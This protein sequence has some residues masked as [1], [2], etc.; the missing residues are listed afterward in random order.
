MSPKTRIAL[1][2]ATLLIASLA[3]TTI[4]QGF[5]ADTPTPPDTPTDT[6]TPLPI[7]STAPAASSSAPLTGSEIL[8]S[9]DFSD[10]SSGWD[11]YSDAE[12]YT[13]YA[14]GAYQ[15]GIYTDNYFY[16]ANPYL[17][18]GDVIVTVEGEKIAGDDDMEYGII[19]HHVDVNNWYAL[20]IS[21]DGYAYIG[22]R[23]QGGDMENITG[24][25][26]APAVNTGNAS[27]V[28]QAECIGDRLSL[29]ANGELVVELY[30]SDLTGGDVG[31]MTGTYDQSLTEV[32]FDN[33]TVLAP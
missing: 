24:W 19:C 14:N 6:D 26:Q 28:L 23:Y 27:N 13:D 1:A 12:G 9:D 16:W 2:L 4:T 31:L 30:D 5:S 20:V 18:F 25:V 32:L 21:G 22:K 10:S 17:T 3:C 8:F 7:E 15:I 29:Y 33:F 11:Q